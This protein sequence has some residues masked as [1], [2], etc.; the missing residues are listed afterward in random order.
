MTEYPVSGGTPTPLQ[1]DPEMETITASY[2]QPLIAGLRRG[3]MLEDPGLTGSW[4][5]VN[6]AATRR[7]KAALRLTRANAV[8]QVHENPQ[9]G[10]RY[11]SVMGRFGA[12]VQP[13]I[14]RPKS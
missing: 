6:D 5:P 14:S 11:K 13:D 12:N 7:P 1:A 9:G 4:L 2:R 10:A 3:G 8:L